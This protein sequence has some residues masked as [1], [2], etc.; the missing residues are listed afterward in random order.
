MYPRKN[1]LFKHIDFII[2]DILCM[3]VSFIFAYFLRHRN[4]S[5]FDE[6]SYRSVLIILL[7]ANLLSCNIFDTMQD[8][9]K[10]SKQ[11]EFYSTVKQ[12]LFTTAMLLAYIYFVRIG[13]DISRNTIILFPFIYLIISYIARLIYKY[14]LNSHFGKLSDTDKARLYARHIVIIADK[15]NA[16]RLI[17]KIYNGHNDISIDCVLQLD[18]DINPC[19]KILFKPVVGASSL[20]IKYLQTQH[21]D[22]VIISTNGKDVGELIQKISL[23]G[24]V[25][26]IELPKEYDFIGD[27]SKLFVESISDI[28]FL[29]STVNTINP[30][31]L[32]AKRFIDIIFGIIGTIMTLIFAIIIGPIIKIKSK[33]PIF[34]MQDRVGRNGKIFKMIKFR[35]MVVDADELKEKYKTQ[36][37]NKDGLMF[38]M[39][40]DPRVIPGIG[41]F[42]RKTSIDEFPQFINVLKGE[43]SVVGTRPPT[44]DEWE[45][46]DLHHRARLAIKP[47][48]T[49]LWQVSGRSDIKD[50]EDVVKL[51]TKY[52]KTFSLWQDFSIILK[53][54]K[55]VLNKEGAR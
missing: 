24:I 53:T 20:A 15:I 29:T 38:K 52:I 27:N 19:S 3:E 6:S 22:E 1:K 44:V 16:E 37:E 35:S 34:F 5:L 46:Y 13:V 7:I 42:I 41:D 49:G 26:H 54:I 45:K 23:M 30:M 32:V 25:L 4:F 39:T 8:V 48:I 17:K 10:K 33:G 51:D 47:G 21:V 50:F 2:L 36:N 55:V 40:N 28:N 9:L 43:M 12:V 18:Y 14:I 11:L 31:Q